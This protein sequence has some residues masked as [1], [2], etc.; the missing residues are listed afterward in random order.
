VRGGSLTRRVRQVPQ[1]GPEIELVD[2]V[3]E[4]HRRGGGTM[5]SAGASTGED[6]VALAGS[7]HGDV[8]LVAEDVDHT[9]GGAGKAEGRHRLPSAIPP[10]GLV[11]EAALA[12]LAQC[13]P[14]HRPQ[15]PGA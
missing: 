5:S 13:E 2:H 12:Q 3:Y 6:P 7:D 15:R 10:A 11:L 1:T 8:E 4:P 14:A 9:R